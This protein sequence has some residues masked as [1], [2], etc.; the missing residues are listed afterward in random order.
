M[1]TGIIEEVG[2][3]ER[4]EKRS[5]SAVLHIKAV[6]VLSGTEIGDSIAVN[7]ICLTVSGIRNGCFSADATPETVSK[8]SLSALHQG[9]AVNLERAARADGRL[10]GHIVMGHVD[11]TGTVLSITEDGNSLLLSVRSSDEIMRYIVR[12]GSVAIDGISLTVAALSD[13][14]FTVSVIPH[15]AEHTTI[16]L[17]RMGSTVNIENDIIGK[18]VERLLHMQKHEGIT[19]GFLAEYGFMEVEDE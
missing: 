15:T 12:K 9:S 10:G 5:G 3:I 2:T 17:L 18:Y 8:T 7:G 4:I 16:H 6:R 11:G 14:S 19:A 1:F 13:S